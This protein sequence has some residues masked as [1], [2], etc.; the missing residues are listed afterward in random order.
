M[1]E[2]VGDGSTGENPQVA[3]PTH[4]AFD[5]EALAAIDQD[6]AKYPPGRQASAVIAAPAVANSA[7]LRAES[8]P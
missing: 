6:V 1:A 5:A 4:F 2:N 7:M 3:Q 8:Q